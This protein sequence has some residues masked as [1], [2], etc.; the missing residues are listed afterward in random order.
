MKST[1]LALAVLAAACAGANAG[2]TVEQPCHD[3]IIPGYAPP[4]CNVKAKT[5]FRLHRSTV[6]VRNL[7]V[8]AA[9]NKNK[10]TKV[11]DCACNDGRAPVK[12]V[13]PILEISDCAI[14][15]EGCTSTKNAVKGR[16]ES[17]KNIKKGRTPCKTCISNIGTPGTP[18][19]GGKCGMA[20]VHAQYTSTFGKNLYQYNTEK[21]L[22]QNK[23]VDREDW[24]ASLAEDCAVLCDM[25]DEC[26]AFLYIFGSCQFLGQLSTWQSVSNV[27]DKQSIQPGTWIY[28]A[29]STSVDR[30]TEHKRV[31]EALSLPWPAPNLA[32]PTCD[33]YFSLGVPCQ[34]ETTGGT[35]EI[36]RD[37]DLDEDD[38]VNSLTLSTGDTWSGA[39]PSAFDTDLVTFESGG[40][41][42]LETRHDDGSLGF[43]FPDADADC[44][45][46]YNTYATSIVAGKV[47]SGYGFYE[48]TM[49][50]TAVEF[51]NTFWL[52]GRTA[53]INVL[54]VENGL[55]TVSWY[56]FADQVD[57]QQGASDS[58]QLDITEATTATL[59]YSEDR[60]TVL[61]NGARVYSVATP[62]CLKGAEMKPI[63]SVEVG[64]TLPSTDGVANG[65]SFGAMK[66]KYFRSWDTK[67]I[68]STL[69]TD[70]YFCY[71]NKDADPTKTRPRVGFG[72]NE[73]VGDAGTY[74]GVYVGPVPTETTRWIAQ[75][76]IQGQGIRKIRVTPHKSIGECGEMCELTSGCTSFTY[77]YTRGNPNKLNTTAGGGVDKTQKNKNKEKSSVCTLFADK[78]LYAQSK[79][80]DEKSAESQGHV[81]FA[82]HDK[83]PA[84]IPVP[85]TAGG[86][87]SNYITHC[88][89]GSSGYGFQSAVDVD[90]DGTLDFGCPIATASTGKQCSTDQCPDKSLYDDNGGGLEKFKCPTNSEGNINRPAKK[91]TKAKW[92]ELGLD[93]SSRGEFYGER[94]PGQNV[95]SNLPL[96]LALCD[97]DCTCAAVSYM[98]QKNECYLQSK[99]PY[100]KYRTC[101]NCGT[102]PP[103]PYFGYSI[104]YKALAKVQAA[105]N[106]STIEFPVDIPV[107]GANGI[108][109]IDNLMALGGQN[110]DGREL[111]CSEATLKAAYPLAF[112]A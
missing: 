1:Q 30:D 108:Q 58:F 24:E 9:N 8:G 36:S 75:C 93:K 77:A 94:I 72:H 2:F 92:D 27:G 88:N 57:Q 29:K 95:P 74:T 71:Y 64:E 56:C 112:P 86:L 14:C 68:K 67:Y 100:R 82:T 65:D 47:V 17:A 61:V 96:C 12:N 78:A 31:V 33:S 99:N 103:I 45:C 43:T 23:V 15:E 79:H 109:G 76:G 10:F 81:Y 3:D 83:E 60:I 111:T 37:V 28:Y 42:T 106:A 20:E 87:N 101:N 63:F 25:H 62:E 34:V 89:A 102:T 39:A 11:M 40:G 51:A 5:M 22:T 107:K 13:C 69:A 19:N 18:G 48:V 26:D 46:E 44:A 21:K 52:Q 41:I 66:V 7:N 53:E 16:C 54:K 70:D 104:H 105:N 35:F 80:D 85:C 59:F 90:D 55:A 98:E 32:S 73:G 6:S 38:F 84:G 97:D 50:S 4:V 49:S 91:I 110:K